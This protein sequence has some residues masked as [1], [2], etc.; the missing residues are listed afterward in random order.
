MTDPRSSAALAD[1]DNA[2]HRENRIR[3]E[4]YCIWV[5]RQVV[6]DLVEQLDQRL[7]HQGRQGE[8]AHLL[9]VRPRRL[10]DIGTGYVQH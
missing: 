8:I 10:P 4:S 7:R 6:A 9:T 5:F 2:G 1:R 3:I